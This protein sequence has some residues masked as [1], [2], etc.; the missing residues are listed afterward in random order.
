M[1]TD[2]LVKLGA[3]YEF[4]RILSMEAEWIPS[5]GTSIGGIIQCCFINNPE[6]MVFGKSSF[7]ALATT[8]ANEQGMTAHQ[9]NLG[10]VKRYDN[11]RATSRT[12]Y[13]CVDPTESANS[14]VL[15]RQVPTMFGSVLTGQNGTTY[16]YWIFRVKM[17]FKGLGDSRDLAPPS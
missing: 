7:A 4:F 9:A 11:T 14:D 12:W 10:F 6:L 1:F 5:V 13:A 15:D 16:G 17:A 2:P 3:A 8:V